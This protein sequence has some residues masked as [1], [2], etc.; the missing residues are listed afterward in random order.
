M[1]EVVIVTLISSRL[2]IHSS[3]VVQDSDLHT[4][5]QA[6]NLVRMGILSRGDL[7]TGNRVSWR[8][9]GSEVHGVAV[10]RTTGSDGSLAASGAPTILRGLL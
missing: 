3:G 8:L 9:D 5:L 6:T 1:P 10:G 7:C 2:N 4:V